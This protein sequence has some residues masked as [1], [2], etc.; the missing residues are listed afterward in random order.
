MTG[1]HQQESA[2]ANTIKP[3][4]EFYDYTLSL[5]ESAAVSEQP[6]GYDTLHSELKFSFK[7]N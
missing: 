6:S 4:G 1:I 7:L 3:S 2:K 5:V